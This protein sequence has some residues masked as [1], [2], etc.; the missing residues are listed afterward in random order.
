[1]SPFLRNLKHKSFI[2]LAKFMVNFAPSASYMAFAG[3]G[4]AAQLARHIVRT[5]VRRVLVV[6]D[7]PLRELG[8]VDRVVEGLVAAGVDVA[9]YDGVQPD[10][11]FDQ[12]AAGAEVLRT[13]GSEAVLAV[14]G[15]SSID[16]AKIIAASATSAENPKD[17]VGFG[18][19]KHEVLPLYAVPTTSGTG[20][21]ATMGA[22]IS[23]SV[24]HEKGI[25]S[26]SSLLPAAA[27]LDPEL[28]TGLPAPITA[29]TGMDALTHGIEAYIC[30]WDRGTRLEHSRA[31]IRLVFE[32]LRTACADGG[33][34]EAREGM[35]MAAYYA[36]IAINQVNVGNVH[37][38]AHQLGGKYGIP[39]GL[40]NA[41]V[42]P[43]VLE[44]CREEA[45][46]RL[47][48]L[49]LLVGVGS[50]GASEA[51]LAQ[52]FIDAV[53]DLRSAVGIPER[54]DKIQAGD[55]DYL[56][57]LALAECESY[58]VPRLLDRENTLAILANIT[59][60]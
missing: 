46:P 33:N 51:Q 14:G 12:V 38:I 31:A 57:D 59:A 58:P 39:H 29:A 4:S 50:P 41:M 19:V 28:I 56:C 21:E 13:H 10:P 6:T 7:K 37:A 25:I 45:R 5:G 20:S 22:V 2:A 43:H 52:S 36:G 9:Y 32:H 30:T 24:S 42:L 34:L 3:R 26:G 47:A 11:T 15:G 23:D 16:A 53:R 40:A 1:M 44:F 17:W 48:E 27:A 49:A 60:S 35:S 54:S 8:L 55:Y 18:K